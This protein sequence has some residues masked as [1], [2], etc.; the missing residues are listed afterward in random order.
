MLLGSRA[1]DVLDVLVG[2]A[3]DLVSRDEFMTAVWPAT[4]VEDTNLNMQIAALRRALDEGRADG[5]CIQTIPG[6]GY[7]FAV[8]VIRVESALPSSG[9]PTGN[10]AGGS[11]A[12]QPEP[13]NP[14]PPSR[15]G[16]TPPVI[17]AR[18]RK[19]L[20]CG[21]LGVV[22][23]ALCLLAVAITGSN[24]QL[25]QPEAAG[26][27]PRLSIVVLPF[28]DLS[29]D[30]DER[31]FASSITED[32][33][34][35][36]S[37]ISDMRVT[38]RNTAFTYGNKFVDTNRIG[39]ELN[40]RYVLEGSVQ[41]S[42]NQMRVNAQLVDAKTD[43]NLWAERFD[44]DIGDPF[45]LQNEITRRLANALS[46]EL[47]AAEALRPTER[48]D[49]LGYILRGRAA[50][51]RLP[52][53]ENFAEQISLFQHA[54]ALD[55]RSVEGQ[56]RLAI[57]LAGRVLNGVTDAAAADLARA[58]GLV[59]QALAASPRYSYAHH[60]KAT[61]L[62]AQNRCE[63]AI[64][65]YETALALNCNQVYAII[66][67][68][69]CKVDAGS[70]DEAIPLAEQAI[71]L[72][73]HDPGVGWWYG[74]IGI[75]RLLQSRTD[76]AILWLEQARTAIPAIP[77]HHSR[78]AAAYA[79]KGDIE[80]AAAELAEARRLAGD[81]R[82][83]SIA[84]MRAGGCCGSPKTRALFDATLFAGLRKAGVPEN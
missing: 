62:R 66:G 63:E 18:E 35:D 77:A 15:S 49:A 9:R 52:S 64:P 24:W 19:W 58:E 8:P 21:C 32:L 40:V 53:R 68:G 23:G 37:L 80:R 34:A 20:W 4:V 67:L 12:L 55:P 39:R 57:A 41:R 3:G 69:W 84:R 50:V 14:A 33:T 51:L 27:T 25:R 10:G 45:A 81:D 60:T 7:R 59:G 29:D 30:A 71:R 61:V 43:S 65:E 1:L 47:I 38:S 72:K 78:L 26:P 74:Q 79:L 70:L 54:L 46:D 76:E 17:P 13:E 48:P 36:L 31:Q 42:G 5:S 16:T 44:G 2:R 22:A 82:Y 6:R 56:S 28:T 83:S 73:P 75:V 11:V